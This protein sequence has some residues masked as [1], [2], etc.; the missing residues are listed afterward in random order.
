MT[1]GEGGGLKIYELNLWTFVL[2]WHIIQAT[3][4][5]LVLLSIYT[6]SPPAEDFVSLNHGFGMLLFA[7]TANF[8]PKCKLVNALGLTPFLSFH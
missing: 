3:L 2:K 4:K 1:Q 5:G 7:I 6:F 8:M